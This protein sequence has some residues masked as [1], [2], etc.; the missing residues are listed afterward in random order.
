MKKIVGLL[1]GV[2]LSAGSF[3]QVQIGIQGTG[4]LATWQQPRSNLKNSLITLKT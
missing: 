2:I 3:A 4:N 1:T